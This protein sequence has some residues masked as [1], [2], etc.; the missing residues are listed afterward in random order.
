VPSEGRLRPS[1]TILMRGLPVDIGLRVIPSSESG[2]EFLGRMRTHTRAV[3]C[4]M[5]GAENPAAAM[6]DNMQNR[7]NAFG[8]KEP[9]SIHF[10]IDQ[11]GDIYQ[12]ADTEMRCA[13]AVGKGQERSANGWS[14][15]IEFIGRGSDL[16][17]PTR[18]YTRERITTMLHGRPV[19]MDELFDAQVSAGVKL[20]EKLCGLYGL[21]MRVPEDAGGSVL[22]RT[23]ADALYDSFHGVMAHPH[24]EAGKTDL[25]PK[26]MRA[27]QARGRE[28]ERART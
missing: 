24:V 13:H 2:C 10:C 28:L 21:P 27:I 12:M 1:T 17:R 18:G 9:L 15:G 8:V 6:F 11:R 4:H 7:R 5:T 23:I 14:I 3:I 22:T 25:S 20:V 19:E 16:K 26:L